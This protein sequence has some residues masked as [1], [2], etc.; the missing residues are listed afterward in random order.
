MDPVV[1]LSNS[2]TRAMRYQD[3]PTVEVTTSINASAEEVWQMVSDISTP[4]T[5]SEELQATEWLDGG[6]SPKVGSTF[7]GRNRHPQVG[8]WEVTCTVIDYEP[9][10]VFGWAVGDLEGPAA[11]WWFT[12]AEAAETGSITLSQKATLGPGPSGL[13]AAI[14]RMPDKE[15]KIIDNRLGQLR[16]NMEANLAG[17]KA[18][19]EGQP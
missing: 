12:I 9:N 14:E 15:A 8:E 5:Y 10:R 19:L 4:V 3:G 18:T 13:S 17:I 1:W 11:R 2:Y 6:D 7:K 16:G